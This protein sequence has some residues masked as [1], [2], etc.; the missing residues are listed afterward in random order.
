MLERTE[1]YRTADVTA[2]KERS[3]EEFAL[4]KEL[5]QSL[6]I[7][8]FKYPSPIQTQ[9]IPLIMGGKSVVAHAKNGTG[10]TAAYVIPVLSSLSSFDPRVQALVLQPTRELAVQTHLLVEELCEPLGLGS[11]CVTGGTSLKQDILSLV[12]GRQIVVGTPGRVVDL[13]SK[14]LLSLERLKVLVLDEVDQLLSQDFTPVIEQLVFFVSSIHV[15]IVAIS[16]T[17]PAE[18]SQFVEKYMSSV[19]TLNAMA[20]LTL[21]GVRQFYVLLPEE[22]KVQRLYDLMCSLTINQLIVFCNSNKRVEYVSQMLTSL[23]VPNLFIH[24]K[25]PQPE[26]AQVMADF[27]EGKR[28]VLVSSDLLNRGIDVPNINVVVNYD[29]PKDEQTYIHRIGRGGRFGLLALAINFVKETDKKNLIQFQTTLKT[30]IEPLP[31]DADRFTSML[32]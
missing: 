3:F 16:A 4:P 8:G 25:L 6:A 31:T 23:G 11:L 2:T 13:M 20:E 9:L 18:T 29:F 5:L 24:A 1:Q 14:S 28:R 7:K 10:K 26:R 12:G 19:T 17:F 30:D 15:Q 22:D 32:I 27:C 21:I